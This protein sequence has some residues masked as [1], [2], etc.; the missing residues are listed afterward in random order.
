MRIRLTLLAIVTLAAVAW[1]AVD[2][3]LMADGRSG[4]P[5]SAQAAGQAATTEIDAE[6]SAATEE[7]TPRPS[8]ATSTTTPKAA[9]I[10]AF[11]STDGA[12][13]PA[14]PASESES[15]G[16][17]LA[18]LERRARAG[19]RKAARDWFDALIQCAAVSSNLQLGSTRTHLSH[20]DWNLYEPQHA[21]RIE[22]LGS[23]VDECR[24]LFP[25]TDSQQAML[26]L[27][28]LIREAIGLWAAS[29]DP[30]GQLAQANFDSV[31]PP[32]PDEWQRQQALAAAH[33]DAANPQTLIDLA[34]FY[35]DA[36]RFSSQTAWRLAAC[37]LGYD[38]SA[39]GALQRVLCMR[40]LQCFQ[41]SY[42][43]EL[44][45]RLPPRQWQIAQAQRRA[46]VEMLRRG[47]TAAIFDV[48][49]PRP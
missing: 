13:T 46:L 33:L 41:G 45:Q 21:L 23:L 4:Q 16:A 27:H 38:C 28:N 35:T 7:T 44:L 24:L 47:E 14:E 34:E 15:P 49:P 8:S 37:D 20:L 5:A 39:G 36:S 9:A 2:Q 32:P 22:L 19:D 26:Q 31:W 48:P 42:E 3:G 18:A 11:S 43:E 25:A 10:T 30:F 1:I 12:D 6:R 17:R 29:G 40:E